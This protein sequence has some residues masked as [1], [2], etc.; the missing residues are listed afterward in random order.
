MA[1]ASDAPRA[2]KKKAG[3]RSAESE[4]ALMALAENRLAIE[5]VTPEIDGGRFAVKRVEGEDLTISADVF[6]DGH[7]KIACA[8]VYGPSTAEKWSEEP[9]VFVENDRWAATIRFDKAGPY[10]YS[11]IAWRDLYATWRD[12]AKKK[13]DAGKLTDL[14]LIEARELVRAAQGSGRGSKAEQNVA[15]APAN[16]P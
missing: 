16:I 15:T 6:S 8:V 11:I 3:R 12:E 13:R 7:D 4:A 14:E 1:E 10:R 9:L 5:G 2:T